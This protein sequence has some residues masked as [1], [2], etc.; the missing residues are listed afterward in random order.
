MREV[1]GGVERGEREIAPDGTIGH[2]EVQVGDSVL[3]LSEASL[4]YPARPSVN[5]A[6]VTDV[7]FVFR[8]AIAAGSTAIMEPVMQPWGDRKADSM[9]RSTI[10]GGWPRESRD[11]DSGRRVGRF[12]R[13]SENL[14]SASNGGDVGRR[15]RHSVDTTSGVVVPDPHAVLERRD[16][17]LTERAGMSL[18]AGASAPPR[19]VTGAQYPALVGAI[20]V[21]LLMAR[22][23]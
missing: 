19:P 11:A 15:Q 12:D 9:I 5:F 16:C 3:M 2:T 22:P 18:D 14:F 8:A 4:A 10:G 23:W 6:Y 21:T 13:I 1:F 7:D 20:A 17:K